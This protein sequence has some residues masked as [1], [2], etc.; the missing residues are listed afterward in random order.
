L[1]NTKKREFETKDITLYE[2]QFQ[3]FLGGAL[4]LLFLDILFL[5]RRTAWIAKLNLFN[6]KE[7]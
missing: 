6:E 1:G 2:S 3:W 7:S 4:L 5:E